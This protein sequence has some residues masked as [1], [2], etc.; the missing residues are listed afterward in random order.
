VPILTVCVRVCVCACVCVCAR[1]CV[2]VR[3]CACACSDCAS[4]RVHRQHSLA[5]LPGNLECSAASSAGPTPPCASACSFAH[6]RDTLLLPRVL[7]SPLAPIFC[8]GQLS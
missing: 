4:T 7:I 3:V 1:V 2:L 8:T 6:L 5:Q